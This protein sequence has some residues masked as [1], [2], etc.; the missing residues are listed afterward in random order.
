LFEEYKCLTKVV[1]IPLDSTITPNYTIGR[2]ESEMTEH[3]CENCPMR[4]KAEANPKSL[5]SK[6]WKWHTGWCPG[7]K[8]Y[9]KSLAEKEG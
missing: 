7:W 2:K 1:F 8:D 3:R 6:I 4:Q 9:Q 5:M